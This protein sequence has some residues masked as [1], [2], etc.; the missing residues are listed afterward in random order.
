MDNLATVIVSALIGA[1]VSALGAILQSRLAARTKIDESLRT[2]RIAVYKL[3]WKKTELLPL[4]PRTKGVTYEKLEKFSAELRDW[5]FSDGGLFFSTQAR[6]AYEGLQT[7]LRDVVQQNAG[8]G[9]E[10]ISPEH[11]ETIRSRCSSLRT[12]LT[13]DLQSRKR[14]MFL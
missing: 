2:D 7:Q 12:E 3:L 9:G 6:Q 5:Y 8:K 10:E 14:A 1:A 13:N 11:Y 4:W